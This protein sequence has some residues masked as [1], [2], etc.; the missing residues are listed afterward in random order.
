MLDPRFF[1]HRITLVNATRFVIVLFLIVSFGIVIIDTAFL[2]NRPKIQPEQ[3]LEKQQS[4]WIQHSG[5][6]S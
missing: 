4:S 3:A 2:A 6:G 1:E 5:P